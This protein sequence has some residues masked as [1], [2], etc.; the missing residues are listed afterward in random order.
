MTMSE[1]RPTPSLLE[2]QSSGGDRAEAGFSFQESILLVKVPGWLAQDGFT[3]VI[4]EAIGDIEAQFFDP[5]KGT[6]K[7]C[8]EVKN[9][10]VSSTK[11]WNEIKRFYEIQA[12]SSKTYRQFSLI[13]T[14]VSDKIKPLLNGLKRYRNPEKFYSDSPAI[15]RNSY[16]DYLEIIERLGQTEEIARFLLDKV[17]IETDWSSAKTHAE[18]LFN[19]SLLEHFSEY[20]EVPTRTLK[21]VYEALSSLVRKRR[22]KPIRRKEI[23]AIFREQLPAELN[24]SEQSIKLLTKTNTSSISETTALQF[25]WVAFFGGEARDYPTC[26]EWQSVLIKDLHRTQDWIVKHRCTR[27][28]RLQGS[29]RLSASV[30]IGSVF[31]SVA[32]FSLD[33]EYR[34]ELW[35]TNAYPTPETPDYALQENSAEGES[36]E[37]IVSVGILR[38]IASQ[39][40]RSR[41]DLELQNIPSLHI[42]GDQAI[43]SAEQANLIARKLKDLIS[44]KVSDYSIRIIHLFLATPAPLALFL[45][46]RLNAIASVQCYEW[47]GSNRYIPTCQISLVNTKGDS[48]PI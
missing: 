20:E 11:F 18:S 43:T 45:G 2:P 5:R 47:I 41:P 17:S 12:G 6:Q 46:H 16:K 9:H 42:Q 31:S 35:A 4:R 15:Q 8:L 26:E 30:A 28:I 39:V 10:H 25:E 27:R 21:K 7:E 3:A 24:P 44:A 1:D 19:Q 22:N 48:T 29:R 37:M 33:V 38:N 13:T 40:E 14:G 36:D 32:G 34:G 23:E